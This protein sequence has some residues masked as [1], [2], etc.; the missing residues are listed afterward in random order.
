[1]A[2]GSWLLTTTARTLPKRIFETQRSAM[3]F[4]TPSSESSFVVRMDDEEHAPTPSVEVQGIVE[5]P[6]EIVNVEISG[7]IIP[8]GR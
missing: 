4:S 6:V 1:M 7:C 3:A 8:F 5:S 2:E